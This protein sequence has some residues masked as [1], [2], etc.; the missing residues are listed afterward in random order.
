MFE[1]ETELVDLAAR[2][3]AEWRSRQWS[4]FEV[5][6]IDR[7][8]ASRRGES[9][10]FERSE[11]QWLSGGEEISYTAASDLLYA[12][13]DAE[14]EEVVA[15]PDSAPAGEPLVELVLETAGGSETLRL[16]PRDGDRYPATRDGREVVLY[17][18]PSAVDELTAKLDEA[19]R[20]EPL[21][22]VPAAEDDATD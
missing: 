17:L 8:S 4:R 12:V 7:V 5:Y 16:W 9:L 10:A 18:P 13:R 6:E 20:A 2:P 11:G 21:A 19:L 3:A 15:R 22:A 1:T 14:A